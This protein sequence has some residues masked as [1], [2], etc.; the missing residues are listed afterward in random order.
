[1]LHDRADPEEGHEACHEEDGAQDEVR[2]QGNQHERHQGRGVPK[3]HVA[4]P[5]QDVT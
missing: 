5:A 2:G 3:P 4:D 1:V